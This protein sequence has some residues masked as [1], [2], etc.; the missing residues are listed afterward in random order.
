MLVNFKGFEII[1]GP[2]KIIESMSEERKKEFVITILSAVQDQG[3][4]DRNG[5]IKIQADFT[6]PTNESKNAIGILNL[7][8]KKYHHS[9]PDF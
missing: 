4:W 5:D 6:L 9:L 2:R 3:D 7:I 1:V 8:L